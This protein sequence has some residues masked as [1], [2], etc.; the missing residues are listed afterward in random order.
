MLVVSFNNEKG[1]CGKSTTTIHMARAASQQGKK[2][3]I[4]DLDPQG[5][6]TSA[7]S[8]NELAEDVA[9]VA[10]VI[11]PN[12]PMQLSEIIVPTVWDGV[13]LAPTPSDLPLKT[14]LNLLTVMQLG[15]ESRVKEA[16]E[17]L[18]ADAYDLV[19]IDCPPASNKLTVNAMAAADQVVVV[20]EPGFW[21]IKGI[22]MVLDSLSLVKK[23]V[24]PDVKF[25]GILVS[26]YDKRIGNHAEYHRQI[27][28]HGQILG[29]KIF[30]PA[31]PLLDAVGN[32]A[33]EGLP[34]DENKSERI[35]TVGKSYAR[36]VRELMK[37]EK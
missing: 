16:L 11:T 14:V 17:G 10:D 20:T 27:K 2:V 34:L 1:G 19:L 31:I 4:L 22:D 25:A 6:T 23:F 5:N 13:D 15:S 7:I 30:D 18:P 29:V 26:R 8:K 3:L 12:D 28:E 37:E 36:F 21:S 9:G 35:R 32:G 33:A 24:N